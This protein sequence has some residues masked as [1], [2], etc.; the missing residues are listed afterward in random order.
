VTDTTAPTIGALTASPSVVS[1]PNHRLFSVVVD[2]STADLSGAPVCALSV[3][4]NEPVDGGGDGDTAPDWILGDA[5]HLQLRAERAGAGSGRI[6]TIAATCTDAF[7]NAASKST[8][9]A[10]PK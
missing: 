7:G 10:V 3:T 1:V 9:V 8:T 4:S 5:H 2:Y 6:Y